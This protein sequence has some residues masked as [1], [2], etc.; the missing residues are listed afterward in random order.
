VR[1][2]RVEVTIRASADSLA[3]AIDQVRGAGGAH[4]GVVERFE[5]RLDVS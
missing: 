1:R 3:T 2:N 5:H 4:V